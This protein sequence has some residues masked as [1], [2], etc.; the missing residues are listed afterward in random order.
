MAKPIRRVSL[1]RSGR[2]A[3]TKRAIN[4]VVPTFKARKM[5]SRKNTGWLVN[6]TAAMAAEPR[7]PTIIMSA[8]PTRLLSIISTKAGAE[9]SQTR[10]R[11]S[12]VDG[13]AANSTVPA[14]ASLSNARFPF[15]ITRHS[16]PL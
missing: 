12:F 13:V 15:G 4:A 11:I 7:R 16:S 3:P 6:P 9:R 1:A 10:Q 2:L 5:A 14:S 8:M